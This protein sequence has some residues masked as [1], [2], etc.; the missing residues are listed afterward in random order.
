MTNRGKV[1]V[2]VSMIFQTS[3]DSSICVTEPDSNEEIW[4]PKSQIEYDDTAERGD[5]IDVEIRTWLA[6]KKGLA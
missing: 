1:Y 4:L 5:R 2:T 3:T 6:E